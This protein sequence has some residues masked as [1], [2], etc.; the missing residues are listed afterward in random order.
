MK[1]FIS[2]CVALV[3]ASVATS[4]SAQNII[5]RWSVDSKALMGADESMGASE[6]SLIYDFRADGSCIC[7]ADITMTVPL[8]TEEGVTMEFDM[9]MSANLSWRLADNKLCFT[10]NDVSLG[11]GDLRISPQSDEYVA[12]VPMLREMLVSEF[13]LSRNTMLNQFGVKDSELTVNFPTPDTMYITGDTK[14]LVLTRL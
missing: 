8:S 10:P 11:V 3:V 2:L 6:L 1:R 5:G 4:V 13:E 7:T 9:T 14:T 12:L